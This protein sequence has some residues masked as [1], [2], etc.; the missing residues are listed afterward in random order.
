MATRKPR[1]HRKPKPK[2]ALW[3]GHALTPS[4]DNVT[5]HFSSNVVVNGIPDFPVDGVQPTGVEIVTPH[6]VKLTYPFP[7]AGLP[8]TFPG[9]SKNLNSAIGGQL[10][11]RIGT[12]PV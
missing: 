1:K 5:L 6:T 11:G 4:G 9:T 12:F 2:P 7:V 3:V 8:Y 10:L